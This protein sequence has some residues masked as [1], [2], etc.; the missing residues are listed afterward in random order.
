MTLHAF[1]EVDLY[2]DI[3]ETMALTQ[4]LDLVITAPTVVSVMSGALG[5]PTCMMT[6]GVLLETLGT[7]YSPWFSS[8]LPFVRRWDSGWEQTI[9]A[10]ARRLLV[11]CPDG[12]GSM[13]GRAG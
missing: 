1:E 2:D 7:D 6:Y 13:D 11:S 10:V 4:A 8:L 3:E 5:V 9:E 12:P